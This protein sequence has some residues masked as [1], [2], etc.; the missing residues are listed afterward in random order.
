MTRQRLFVLAA[1]AGV[2]VGAASCNPAGGLCRAAADCTHFDFNFQLLDTVGTDD[3][4]EAV[5]EADYQGQINVLRANSES[6][7]Q[8][9][10]DELQK[11]LACA[12]DEYN[13]DPGRAC[14]IVS[15]SSANPCQGELQ[16]WQ[17]AAQNDGGRCSENQQ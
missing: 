3:D 1:V 7:C 6:V 11:F 5:C 14:D 2:V 13:K 4:S 15:I 12:G 9:E 16:N 10:A 17:N 8:T